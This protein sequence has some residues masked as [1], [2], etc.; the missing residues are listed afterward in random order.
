MIQI[1]SNNSNSNSNNNS[2]SEQKAPSPTA[3]ENTAVSI[4]DELPD[5]P[6]DDEPI[7]YDNLKEYFTEMRAVS[8]QNFLYPKEKLKTN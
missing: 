8:I 6:L 2:D 3:M 5:I 7:E 4:D 1:L